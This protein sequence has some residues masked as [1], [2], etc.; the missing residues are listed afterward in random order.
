VFYPAM[1]AMPRVVSG[2]FHLG[3]KQEWMNV[4]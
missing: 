2:L 1:L 3:D 4:F